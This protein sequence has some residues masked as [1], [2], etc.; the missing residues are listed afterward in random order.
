MFDRLKRLWKGIVS[1]FSYTTFKNI[2]GKDVALTQAMIDAINDWKNMLSGKADWCESYVESLRLEEGI[3]REFADAA[4]VEME[5]QI[6]NNEQLDKTLKKAAVDLNKKMQNGL[7][8]GSLVLRPLGPDK[9]EYITADKMIPI[10]FDDDG[11]PNDI[12]FLSV[13]RVAE[14]NYYFRLERHYFTNGN[15][16][17]ENNCY[18][19]QSRSDIGQRCELENVPEWANIQPGPIIYP[20]MT[21]MDFGYYQ[22]PVE[23]K[24][25]ESGCGVSIYESAI[26]LIRKADRQAARLD[27]EYESGERAIHVDERA[28]KH[29]KGKTYLPKLSNRLYRG[30]NLDDGKDKELFKEYSPQMRDEAY[31]RGL[32][33]CKREIEFNVGLAY[34]DLSDVQNV[35]K[36]ATEVLAS[37]TRKYNRV[38]AIQNN[39]EKCLQDFVEALAF[40]NGCYMSGVE[41]ACK[42]KD[43][44]LTDEES[45]RQQDRQD[46]SMG[47]MSLLEYRMKWYNEDEET[48]RAKLPEQ[49][50]VME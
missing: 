14:N 29:S 2:L 46:V 45:E 27:W 47:A 9:F 1:M 15:L 44:I 20:G 24:I 12:A 30:L 13:K 41:F 18:H 3:C 34:G 11:K 8:L 16:T 10:S 17:I 21:Q 38:T 37:K 40:Y 32:E 23:N 25:D 7:A 28:L 49:N 50:Q 26:G 5:M 36:T 33:E 4:L 48:A 43:S 42:F 35:E 22:N 31:K 19:S 6:L 39:L